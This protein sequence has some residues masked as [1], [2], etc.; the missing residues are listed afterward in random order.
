MVDD[1]GEEQAEQEKACQPA[2]R[3]QDDDANHND[4]E[5][6]GSKYLCQRNQS[7]ECSEHL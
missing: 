3:V 5:N 7:A 6:D 4:Q 2:K 1:S